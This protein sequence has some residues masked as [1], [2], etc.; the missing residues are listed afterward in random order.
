[1]ALRIDYD[2]A[3]VTM[4][5]HDFVALAPRR[6]DYQRGSGLASHAHLG[7][8]VHQAVAAERKKSHGRAFRAEVPLS[9]R[10]EHGGYLIEVRGRADGLLETS[11]GLIVEEVKSSRRPGAALLGR[12]PDDFPLFID[13]LRCYMFMLAAERKVSSGRLCLYSIPDATEH[14]IEIPYDPLTFHSFFT[15]RL[16]LLVNKIE[17]RRLRAEERR[18]AAAQRPWPFEGWRGEQESMALQVSENLADHNSCL[19]QA[20]TGAGKTMATLWAALKAADDSD[21]TLLWATTRGPQQQ[22]VLAA[23]SMINRGQFGVRAVQLGSR[24]R[25]CFLEQPRCNPED[26][27]F[28][29][30]HYTRLDACS[31]RER[32]YPHSP[33]TRADILDLGATEELCP[34]D[35][36]MY[37]GDEAD[38]VICDVAQVFDPMSRLRRWL[39][40]GE[41]GNYLL[42]VDEA[43]ELPA[44]A[45]DWLSAELPAAAL[46]ISLKVPH[47]RR[48]LTNLRRRIEECSWEPPSLA[49]T[50]WV[51]Q[52]SAGIEALL[53]ELGERSMGDEEE[54]LLLLRRLD[55]MRAG[56]EHAQLR[57]GDFEALNP[58]FT[59]GWEHDSRGGSL[60][61]R[62]QDPSDLTGP[63]AAKFAGCVFLSATLSPLPHHRNLFGVTDAPLLAFAD[64][65][66]PERRRVLLA[67]APSTRYRHREHSAEQVAGIIDSC[68]RH[69]D[70]H[71]LLYFPSFAYRDMVLP[72]LSTS[73][74]MLLQPRQ[75]NDEE[76]EAVL[77]RLSEPGPLCFAGVLGGIFGAGI[78]PATG[79]VTGVAVVG[80]A[81]PQIGPERDEIRA[82]FGAQGDDGFHLAYMVPGMRRVVQA[83]GRA[84]RSELDHTAIVLI[85][86]RYAQH[87]VQNLLPEHWS[88]RRV[89]NIEALNQELSEFFN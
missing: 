35:L 4:N 33:S 64:P 76:R 80:P 48:L 11:A 43:H 71:W 16:D 54:V 22:A 84:M 7:N 30:G 6:G 83:A 27:P 88:P 59:L 9:I 50:T 63:M 65:F 51:D 31:P 2:K 57:I 10:R 73:H 61:L 41:E 75:A 5:V 13:Q 15:S 39:A 8:L 46:D 3:R 55:R 38:L 72:L 82:F 18:K 89:K 52:L 23:V 14:R 34:Y 58:G 56:L 74:K 19:L 40:D 25:L 29:A 1:M 49:D 26:C 17:A 42:V 28:A 44:R 36:A 78:D 37:L 70:G 12:S 24:E 87:A 60:I 62:C 67:T 69:G 81:L 79:S 45:R 85:G 86:Q 77:K 47:G 68:M 32:L 53:V 20:P 21:R 66:D